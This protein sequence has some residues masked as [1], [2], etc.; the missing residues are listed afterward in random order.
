ME[1]KEGSDDA[2]LD[3]MDAPREL[4]FEDE[5]PSSNKAET[6]SPLDNE[7]S[8][9]SSPYIDCEPNLGELSMEVTEADF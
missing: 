7:E 2:V 1:C 6:S 8:S 9:S 3:Q 4:L 5:T